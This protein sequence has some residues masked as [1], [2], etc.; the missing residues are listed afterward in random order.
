MSNFRPAARRNARLR[1]ALI[2]PSGSGKSYTMLEILTAL[3]KRPAVID[4]ERGSIEKYARSGAKPAGPGAW[5]FDTCPL[6]VTDP[7]TYVARIAEAA[8]AGFDALGIDSWSH[9]WG[10][11]LEQIDRMGGWVKGGKVVTP[12]I[13]KLVDSV[14]TYPGHVVATIRSKT[15]HEVEKDEAGRAKI[16]KLGTAPVARDGTEYEFDVILDLGLDGTLTPAKTRCPALSGQVFTRPEVLTR[17]VPAL[18]AW[19]DDGAP[20]TE[21]EVLLERVRAAPDVPSLSAIAPEVRAAA[22]AGRITSEDVP[23]IRAA[24]EARKRQ[25]VAEEVPQ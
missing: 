6:D 18:R 25:L 5:E 16:K 9:S 11:A 20:L 12:A 19:L 4:S 7:Q 24:Y 17:I 15:A 10:S 3:S 8:G 2:G 1:L 23:R 13:Q 14:L 22:E 21:G